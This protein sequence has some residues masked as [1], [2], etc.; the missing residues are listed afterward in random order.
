MCL[1]CTTLAK[2]EGLIDDS[3]EDQ[4]LMDA[5]LAAEQRQ[6]NEQTDGVTT[7]IS[8]QDAPRS[9]D[10][11]QEDAA[12]LQACLSAEKSA[13]EQDDNNTTLIFQ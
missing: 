2:T 4:A 9:T 8:Q 5:C 7:H 6:V 1:R 12:L 11:S 10:A 3:Q 13:N